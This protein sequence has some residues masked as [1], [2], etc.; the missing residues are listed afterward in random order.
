MIS[1]S[2]ASFSHASKPPL[3]DNA[4]LHTQAVVVFFSKKCSVQAGIVVR[5]GEKRAREVERRAGS[6]R[7]GSG[8]GQGRAA[9]YR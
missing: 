6:R 2:Y 7:K 1:R 9:C 4:H 8:G 3:P 5:S